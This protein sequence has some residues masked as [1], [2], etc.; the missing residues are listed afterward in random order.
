MTAAARDFKIARRNADGICLVIWRVKRVPVVTPF[1]HVA[2][3]IVQ[4]PWI[5]G[6]TANVQRDRDRRP[7]LG[8]MFM[9]RV[10]QFIAGVESGARSRPAGILPFGFGRQSI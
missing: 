5:G 3:H 9:K 7:F 1:L 8:L 4:A 6:C 10:R 2:M